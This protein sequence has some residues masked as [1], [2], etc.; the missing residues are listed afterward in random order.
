M[1]PTARPYKDFLTP[2]LHRRFTNAALLTLAICWLEATL[3]SSSRS[4]LWFWNPFGLTGFRMILLFTPALAVFIVRVMNMHVGSR[5]TTSAAETVLQK[6]T[7]VRTFGTVGWY[8][9]SAWF[10]AEIYIWSRSA[11]AGLSW[12]D[13]GSDYERA[14]VNENP[15]F[16]RS[17]L[18][19]L[20]VFQSG[21]HLWR[22]YDRVCIEEAEN[23]EHRQEEGAEVPSPPTLLMAQMDAIGIRLAKLVFPGI[24]FSLP[25]YFLFIR[26]AAWDYFAYPVAMV[27]QRELQPNTGP[28]G[29]IHL[30]SLVWQTASSAAM[31]V[32]LWELSNAIFT[33]YVSQAPLKKGQPLTNEI[34][35]ASGAIISR[36]RD[37]NGSLIRGLKAKKDV[38]RAFAFWELYILCTR[39][40]ARRRTIFAEVDRKD[41]STWSQVSRH[42]LAEISAI[43]TRIRKSQEPTQQAA[44]T[45]PQGQQQGALSTQQSQQSLGLPR[46]AQKQV[47]N[48]QNVVQ[49]P[50]RKAN[51]ADTIGNMAR[52]IG[53]SPEKNNPVVQ[54]SRKAIEYGIERAGGR[55]AWSPSGLQK[56]VE[57]RVVTVLK[58]PVG[59]PF[60]QT[61]ART[62]KAVVFG[63]PYSDEINIIHASRS[64]AKLVVCTLQEDNF[65][66]ASK[67]VPIVVRTY[68]TVLQDIR[69]FVATLKPHWSDVYFNDRERDIENNEGLR[70]VREVADVL[71]EGLQEVLLAFGEYASAVNLSRMDLRLAKEAIGQGGKEMEKVR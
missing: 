8:I 33:V 14:R 2:A 62:V 63:V 23:R 34:K 39:F 24:V 43:S 66:Q 48:D 27:L 21:L 51:A 69:T 4:W 44:S 26:R 19:C 64:L 55:E 5:T 6:L 40:E 54:S 7:S 67:D 58:M 28:V 16:L 29:F 46:I 31:L 30:G 42:C 25:I 20:A 71:K 22:D 65:G 52:S 35:D 41:G 9:F 57:E 3:M 59:E 10:F 68:T 18:V 50:M 56:V 17:A 11:K 36:S 15:I 12:V 53:Q 47:V 13:V 37:P 70:E 38:P 49:K 1:V 45:Q 61:F 32:L 60:R